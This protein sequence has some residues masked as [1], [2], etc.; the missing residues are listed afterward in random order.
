[1]SESFTEDSSKSHLTR[2]YQYFTT[3]IFVQD[4]WKAYKNVTIQAGLRADCQNKYGA[5]YL[6]SI[7]FLYQLNQD[8]YLRFGGGVGYKM[9]TIFSTASEQEGINKILPLSAN[10]KAERSTGGN[11]DLNYKAKIG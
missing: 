3:G 6:P 1:V 8:L 7:A 2:D 5:F 9:P 11:I 10:I 4:N